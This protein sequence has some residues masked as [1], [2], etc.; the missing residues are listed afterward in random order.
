MR[1]FYHYLFAALL[2]GF[3]YC[4]IEIIWR[5]RTHYSMF[6]AGAIV[7]SAF[8]YINDNYSLPL[9]AKCFAG[10]LIITAVELIFGIAFNIILREHVWDYSNV[11]LNF[12]GQICVPFSLLWFALSG[13]VF[14]IMEKVSIRM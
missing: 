5:G 4:L 1:N 2:G 6:F 11:P 9:W 13:A 12:M 3:G 14:G 10:M 8:L 7:M